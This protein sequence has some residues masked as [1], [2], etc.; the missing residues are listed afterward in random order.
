MKHRAV[1]WIGTIINIKYQI[2]VV[3]NNF[4]LNHFTKVITYYLHGI[5]L[6][7]IS[8]RLLT[9]EELHIFLRQVFFKVF[10]S[11]PSPAECLEKQ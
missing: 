11:V 3:L 4:A 10:A 8:G 1:L 2:Y 9:L 6:L 7:I 5:M